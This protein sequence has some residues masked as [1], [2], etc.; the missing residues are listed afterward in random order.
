MLIVA[1]DFEDIGVAG[2]GPERRKALRL[3]SDDGVLSS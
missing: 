3:H 1:L 2:E